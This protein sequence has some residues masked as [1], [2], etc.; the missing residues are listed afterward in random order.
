MPKKELQGKKAAQPKKKIPAAPLAANQPASK[1]KK[2]PVFEK[3]PRNFRIGGDI[4]PK[5]NLTRFVKWPAYVKLQRQKRI[6]LERIKVPPSIS[7]FTHTCDKTQFTQ[8]ARLVKKLA[9][10]TKAQKAQRLKDKA[11]GGKDTE[12]KAPAVIKFGLNHVTELVEDKKAKLVII[13]HDV[14]P[15][16]LVCWLPA[17]CKKKDIPYCVV[18]SKSRLGALVNQKTCAAACI[19]TVR[20]ED[21]K[22]LEVLCESFKAAFNEHKAKWGGGIMGVKSQHIERRKQM[23]I[24]K[25]LAKKTGLMM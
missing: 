5:T 9:P 16:E 12:N 19:T 11:A 13:A 14:D 4:Q 7:Q 22:E 10:E 1:V 18:K 6:L 25:E 2:N 17:L 21:Q 20:K 24:E 3:R 23:L 8:L 15:I